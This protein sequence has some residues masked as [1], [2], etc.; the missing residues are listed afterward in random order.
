MS[1]RSRH[2]TPSSGT[3][4][5]SLDPETLKT[6]YFQS[7]QWYPKYHH[8]EIVEALANNEQPNRQLLENDFSAWCGGVHTGYNLAYQPQFN[9]TTLQEALDMVI[10][11]TTEGVPTTRR[12]ATA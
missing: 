8:D 12:R 1:F 7:I 11:Q 5:V 9:E 10:Q 3:T 2:M 6:Y 4:A